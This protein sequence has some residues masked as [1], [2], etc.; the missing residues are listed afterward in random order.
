[1]SLRMVKG[2][3]IIISV[4]V[5]DTNIMS[6]SLPQVLWLKRHLHKKFGNV[7]D[8]PRSCFLGIEVVWDIKGKNF[9]ATST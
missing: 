4:H 8:G 1:M 9:G 3:T 2:R 7:D 5:Y 6:A